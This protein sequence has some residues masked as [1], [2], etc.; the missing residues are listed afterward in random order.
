M[1][2]SAGEIIP[3]F[4]GAKLDDFLKERISSWRPGK[5]VVQVQALLIPLRL[6]HWQYDSFQGN[7]GRRRRPASWRFGW[8]QTGQAAGVTPCDGVEQEFI[9]AFSIS[10]STG[11]RAGDVDQMRPSDSKSVPSSAAVRVGSREPASVI[12]VRDARAGRARRRVVVDTLWRTGADD[13]TSIHLRFA[14]EL[15]AVLAAGAGALL[16]AA[17]RAGG[18]RRRTRLRR[19]VVSPATE[20]FRQVH[21]GRM[22]NLVV[23]CLVL[24]LRSVTSVTAQ[25]GLPDGMDNELSRTL[26][27]GPSAH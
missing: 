6:E 23:L 25:S 15:A 22:A 8:R 24:L 1:F 7:L 26:V 18:D 21:G 2:I 3:A 14:A 20:Q 10:C 11:L 17:G 4:T 12:G 9:Q 19:R 5:L 16:A 13:T 27:A